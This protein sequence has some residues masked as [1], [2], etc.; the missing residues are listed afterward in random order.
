MPKTTTGWKSFWPEPSDSANLPCGLFAEGRRP[1]L[2]GRPGERPAR[3]FCRFTALH[4]LMLTFS[5]GGTVW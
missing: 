4:E 5:L 2:L 1:M 3:M